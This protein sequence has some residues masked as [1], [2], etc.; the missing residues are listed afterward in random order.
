MRTVRVNLGQRSYSVI[1]GNGV[2][3]RLGELVADRARSHRVLLVSN[4][5]VFA[6][7]GDGV[8]NS[9]Q[10]AGLK[11]VTGLVPDGEEYKTLEQA[12]KLIDLAVENRFDRH[13][14]VVA[15]GG[16]VI[17]DLAGFVAAIYQRGIDFVQLP[18]TLLAHV[19]SSIGGKVAVNHPR[20]KNMIGAF[21]QPKIVIIDPAVLATLPPREFKNGMAEVVKYGIILD[22]GFFTW[23]EE[24]LEPI[25][26]REETI[27]AEAIYHSCSLKAR[28]VEEDE[29]EQGKRALLN[30]GHTFG[31]AVETLTGYQQYR[32]GEAVA[33]GIIT[34]CYL[35]ESQGMM[36][37][38][39]AQRVRELQQAL[40]L[41]IQ[42]PRLQPELIMQTM[43]Q[44]KKMLA[45][46]L[47]LVLP[48]GIGRAVIRDDIDDGA[49]LAAINRAMV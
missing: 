33:M 6:L 35:A 20:A 17:G 8:V 23:L 24:E 32:H 5:T 42:L 14:M 30:L 15:L 19:D 9:L 37:T 3:L 41:P 10:E 4:P 39:E 7:Y 34:A 11:V 29:T 13:A 2:Y 26:Q 22:E 48:Q 31:H 49:V 1:I 16:G 25:I 21:Y 43:H 46:R 45:G 38:G 44:D 12:Q 27:I 28:V 40:G 47:R 18:T 36:N